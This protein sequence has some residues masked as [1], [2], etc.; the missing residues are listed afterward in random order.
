MI[1]IMRELPIDL[2]ETFSGIIGEP[3]RTI[4]QEELEHAIFSGVDI[5]I[6]GPVISESVLEKFPDL[7]LIYTLSS[8]VN[9]VPFDY[10]KQHNILLANSRGLHTEHMSEHAMGMI[11]AFSRGLIPALLYQQK[12]EWS[13]GWYPL[14]TVHGKKLCIV[15]SGSIG[16]A[17]ARKAESFGME[18][19][20]V[21]RT[22]HELPHFHRMYTS[23]Q[24]SIAVS[25]ADYV[26]LLTPLTT[27]T[28]HLFNEE[29][30]NCMKKTSIFVNISRGGTVDE[31]SL[32][33][34]L[35]SGGIAGAALDVFQEEPLGE[36]SPFWELDNV[37]ITPHTAG[38]IDD[39]L[40]R[41]FSIFSQ[42]VK[43]YREDQPITNLVDLDHQ[44]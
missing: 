5:L 36:D 14:G 34:A 28:Y 1:A 35:S 12:K 6:S 8:G 40:E 42:V 31:A 18:V 30:F 21:R 25:E 43:E 26:V 29:I 13:Q 7:R 38:M 19:C 44:Y 11:L 24:L 23:D 20:G 10:L 9:S 22:G 37:L 3:I 4:H 32:L 16:R 17:L 33:S 27:E 41:A 15:G 2:A 39:Y